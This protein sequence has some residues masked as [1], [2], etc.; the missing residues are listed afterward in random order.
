MIF[1]HVKGMSLY[2]LISTDECLMFHFSHRIIDKPLIELLTT[3]KDR[4]M[5]EIDR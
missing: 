1:L 5:I 2:N 4:K 3:K